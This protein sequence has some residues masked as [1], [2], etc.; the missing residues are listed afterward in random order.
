MDAVRPRLTRLLAQV[1]E[2]DPASLAA[3]AEDEPLFAE[4]LGLDSLSG[5]RLLAMIDAEFGVDIA[6]EDL[7]LESLESVGTLSRYL[8][9]RA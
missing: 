6:A 7:A 1:L 8:E 2:R 3:L 5:V 4:G 9:G